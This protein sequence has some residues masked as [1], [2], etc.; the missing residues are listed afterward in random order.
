MTIHDRSTGI[1][2]ASARAFLDG[3]FQQ[4]ASGK[5]KKSPP[6]PQSFDLAR[7]NE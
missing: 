2:A 4:Q 5:V 3:E 7:M 1:K 6:V